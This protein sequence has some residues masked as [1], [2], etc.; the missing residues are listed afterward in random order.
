[1]KWL[2]KN[3]LLILSWFQKIEKFYNLIICKQFNKTLLDYINNILKIVCYFSSIL[4]NIWSWVF[5]IW[6]FLIIPILTLFEFETNV[7]C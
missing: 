6:P 7:F 5:I 3:N 4:F 2:L 1:M